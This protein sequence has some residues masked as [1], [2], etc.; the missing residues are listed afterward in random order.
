MVPFPRSPPRGGCTLHDSPFICHSHKVLVWF[1]SSHPDPSHALSLYCKA[2][3]T[4]P[5]PAPARPKGSFHG[6]P[7]R[8]Q[9]R[10]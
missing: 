2:P 8:S 9:L 7:C 3:P 10:L 1:P 6:A 4:K 5:L